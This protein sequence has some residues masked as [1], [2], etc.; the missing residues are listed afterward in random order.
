MPPIVDHKKTLISQ[1]RTLRN[2]A[3]AGEFHRIELP[4]LPIDIS[5][6]LVLQE[7]SV[8]VYWRDRSD[9]FEMAGIGTAMCV[10]DIASQH[11]ASL[12][13]VLHTHLANAP[14]NLRFYGGTC[15]DPRTSLT[16]RWKSFGVARF[17]LPRFEIVRTHRQSL[18]VCN[19]TNADL[20]HHLDRIESEIELIRFEETVKMKRPLSVSINNIP[21]V[22]KWKSQVEEALECIRQRKMDKV[23]LARV[24]EYVCRDLI[25][26]VNIMRY[27]GPTAP[28]TYRFC[29]QIG[30]HDGF[31]GA[32]PERLF[33]R[34]RDRIQ[35]E[36][37]AGTRP[38]GSSDDTDA[39]LSAQLMTNEKERRE[40]AF[41]V[42]RIQSAFNVLCN[43]I[44]NNNDLTVVRLRDCQH[45]HYH[46]DGIIHHSVSDADILSIL[47]PTP[48]VGG[49]P[50][51]TA[52]E[53]IR[54]HEDEPRGW[55]TG[56]VGWVSRDETEFAVA[57]RC[58]RVTGHQFYVHAGAGIVDGS[59]SLLEWNEIEDKMAW[60]SRVIKQADSQEI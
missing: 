3:P 54:T 4:L 56:P 40:H 53:F 55:Y 12:L 60:L 39:A 27:L 58:A 21:A 7:F 57:L 47:H 41:V 44:Q 9:S 50:T 11:P 32:S 1:L 35:S 52:L 16:E 43:M 10:A 5:E 31:L 13:D 38:R 20:Y 8:K 46:F 25:D 36:A 22:S 17:V 2:E 6:W 26:P 28:Q 49:E 42:D 37:I 19:V 45:L 14:V 24:R 48:A 29:F 33:Y 23:V 51:E 30:S 34:R 59:D 18:F 15:F